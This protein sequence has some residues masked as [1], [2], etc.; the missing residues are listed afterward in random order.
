M[1]EGD[2]GA[3]PISPSEREGGFG[4]EVISFSS[5]VV[6]PDIGAP[7]MAVDGVA[8]VDRGVVRTSDRAAA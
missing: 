1:V 7:D 6:F 5:G 8:R 3:D 2:R 4:I